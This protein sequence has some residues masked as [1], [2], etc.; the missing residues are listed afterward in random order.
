MDE[1]GD[2]SLYIHEYQLRVLWF[3]PIF[4]V[5]L[6]VTNMLNLKAQKSKRL[7]VIVVCC[8]ILGGFTTMLVNALAAI[9]VAVPLC[10]YTES[11]MCLLELKDMDR[12][13]E[14]DGSD[15]L[16]IPLLW[17][18][19]T[20]FIAVQVPVM[21]VVVVGGGGGRVKREGRGEGGG[22]CAIV[23]S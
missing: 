22:T 2:E 14:K 9:H 6:A 13:C 10:C 11:S 16:K 12:R 17:L 23:S 21:V 7:A 8:S 19:L 5:V 18:G 4:T 20:I 3:P 15:E 1:E